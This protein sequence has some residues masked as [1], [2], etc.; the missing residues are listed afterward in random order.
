MD[1]YIAQNVLFHD[2]IFPHASNASL[3]KSYVG[4]M[5]SMSLSYL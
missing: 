3:E 5:G 1:I 2:T 4:K